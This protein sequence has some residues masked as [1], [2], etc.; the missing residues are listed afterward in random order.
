MRLV[1]LYY[2]IIVASV[3]FCAA[4]ADAQRLSNPA[5][6][7]ASSN[8]SLNVAVQ[9]VGAGGIT[10]KEPI[11]A[12]LE[13]AG[14]GNVPASAPKVITVQMRG[15]IFAPQYVTARVGDS[16]RYANGDDFNHNV[17][18]QSN[19]DSFDLGSYPL[20]AAVDRTFRFPGLYQV[21][22]NIH[23]QMASFVLVSQTAWHT[24]AEAGKQFTFNEVL[25]GAY[26]LKLWS[27]RGEATREVRV[28]AGQR[29]SVQVN[30]PAI[31]SETGP[32]V[33]KFGKPYKA[34]WNDEIY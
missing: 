34:Q 21:Y 1:T 17:F 16:V 30:I 13:P 23:S 32:H 7:A 6:A 8:G 20:H 28:V 24:V 11:L 29:G 31:S 15:K 14:P 5:S 10:F 4:A 22:C 12:S 3:A 25:P 18:S 9:L 33:N 27:I 2:R 26:I 19:N